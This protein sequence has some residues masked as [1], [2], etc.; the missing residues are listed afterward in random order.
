MKQHAT[1]LDVFSFSL[2]TPIPMPRPSEHGSKGVPEGNKMA[3]KPV[4]AGTEDDEQQDPVTEQTDRHLN[5][6]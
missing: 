6:N 5:H 1:L 4:P 3:A 2:C